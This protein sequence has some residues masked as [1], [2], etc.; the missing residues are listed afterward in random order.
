M[1][2]LL[3]AAGKAQSSSSDSVERVRE[4]R[5]PAVAAAV[6]EAAARA[7]VVRVEAVAEA[8]VEVAMGLGELVVEVKVVEA[9]AVVATAA[10]TAAYSAGWMVAARVAVAWVVVGVGSCVGN[11]GMHTAR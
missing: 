7:A 6:M 4:A 5:S 9:T 3:G 2:T 11:R 8:K 10:P 1:R